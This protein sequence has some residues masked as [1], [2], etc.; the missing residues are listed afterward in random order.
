ML[1]HLVCVCVER[2]Y[3]IIFHHRGDFTHLEKR[4]HPTPGLAIWRRCENRDSLLV[5]DDESQNCL[6]MVAGCDRTQT[7]LGNGMSLNLF[8]QKWS[9]LRR[10]VP[11][12]EAAGSLR[13]CEC[14]ASFTSSPV[15]CSYANARRV[16]TR[17]FPFSFTSSYPLGVQCVA[18]FKLFTHLSTGAAFRKEKV[19][20]GIRLIELVIARYGSLAA[21]VDV[22]VWALF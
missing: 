11:G 4:Q 7:Y 5:V 18:A 3:A 20:S 13:C 16:Q 14:Q 8:S 17:K 21:S 22:C 6:L 10:R 1:H 19:S 12:T 2:M 9:R 15:W